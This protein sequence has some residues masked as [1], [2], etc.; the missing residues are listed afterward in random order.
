M[1]SNGQSFSEGNSFSEGT[2]RECLFIR[3]LLQVAE[4]RA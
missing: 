3:R 4:S 1:H 2:E